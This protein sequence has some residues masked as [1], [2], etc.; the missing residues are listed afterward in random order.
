MEE[1]CWAL[2]KSNTKHLKSSEGI[3]IKEE[4]SNVPFRKVRKTIVTALKTGSG[5][6]ILEG[7]LKT[8]HKITPQLLEVYLT[9]ILKKQVQQRKLKELALFN[10][11]VGRYDP[12]H[13]FL[14]K[15]G[16]KIKRVE[17]KLQVHT[18]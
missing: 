12:K 11:L 10:L 6:D 13:I 15:L 9:E 16:N 1:V 4:F 14:I 2:I 18:E 8:Q 5:D 3:S 17:G 7:L